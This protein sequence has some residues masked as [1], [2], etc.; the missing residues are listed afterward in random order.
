M[1][2]KDTVL[3]ALAVAMMLEN[4]WNWTALTE[5][6]WPRNELRHFPTLTSNIFDK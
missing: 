2:H 3:S 1:S 4:G 5:S 6:T